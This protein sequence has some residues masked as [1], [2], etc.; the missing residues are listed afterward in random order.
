MTE[1]SDNGEGKPARWHLNK[2]I[3][4][5]WLIGSIAIG[6]AQYGGLIWYASQFNTRVENVEK[7]QIS[8]TILVE[9]LRSALAAQNVETAKLGEKVVA[10]Q[11]TANRI[12]ALL[13]KP[14]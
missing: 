14:R 1:F 3:P 5:V 9:N 11:A 13:V 12:E 7:S 2:G 8:A 4:V 10:V 6:L